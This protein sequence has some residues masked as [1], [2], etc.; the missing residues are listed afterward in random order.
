MSR[1]EVCGSASKVNLCKVLGKLEVLDPEDNDNPQSSISMS[2][3]SPEFTT[4][5]P[6]TFQNGKLQ[7]LGPKEEVVI[8]PYDAAARPGSAAG[9]QGSAG[10][11]YIPTKQIPLCTVKP[12]VPSNIPDYVAAPSMQANKPENNKTHT[13]SSTP[14]N[15]DEKEAA[16]PQSLAIH[17]GNI[18][19]RLEESTDEDESDDESGRAPIQLLAEFVTAVMD[20]DYQ[21]AKK[22]CQ[23]ILIYE[24]EN[25]EA[26][27]FSPL[28]EEMLQIGMDEQQQ[29][30]G[31]EDSEDSDEDTDEETDEDTSDTDDNENHCT[32]KHYP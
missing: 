19:G 22:L 11:S 7:V 2:L 23:M 15:T 17:N 13:T 16:G 18:K 28:I 12:L 30:S 24:P 25:P 8:N 6:E 9:R 3:V 5:Q 32:A 26:K 4:K 20:E 27:Q 10:R 21:V 14:R 31:D 29:S 1:A